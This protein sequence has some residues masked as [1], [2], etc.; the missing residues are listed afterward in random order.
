MT[1]RHVSAAALTAIASP[2]ERPQPQHCPEEQY[3]EHLRS[4]GLH[5]Q[6]LSAKLRHYHAFKERWPVLADWFDAP[7]VERVGRLPG[8]PHHQPT[9]PL[10]FRARSYLIYLVEEAVA[11]GFHR[12]SARQAM[13]W[14]LARIGLRTGAL[15]AD[16]V[17]EEHVN[18]AL[19]AV[20]MFSERAGAY[21]DGRTEARVLYAELR[22]R[23]HPLPEAAPASTARRSIP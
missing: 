5:P 2:V 20:R 3:V 19:E 4:Q 18:E 15:H 8:E 9:H 12:A 11:L 1:A 14:T 22:R 7:L 10:S 13:T 21:D 16:G 17:S 23:C 6:Y